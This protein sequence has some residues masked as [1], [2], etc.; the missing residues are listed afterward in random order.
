MCILLKDEF[1][2]CTR[3]LGFSRFHFLCVNSA[4]LLSDGREMKAK[5]FN[6]HY[7][8][9]GLHS[10]WQASNNEMVKLNTTYLIRLTTELILK[11]TDAN[12]VRRCSDRLIHVYSIDLIGIK[13]RK[14]R[15]L[16]L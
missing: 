14:K 2:L 15:L 5:I 8:N 3:F 12:R 13:F 1:A 9:K 7:L 6:S 11:E 16:A 4:N 10:C